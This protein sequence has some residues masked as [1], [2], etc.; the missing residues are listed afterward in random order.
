MGN[1]TGMCLESFFGHPSVLVIELRSSQKLIRSRDLNKAGLFLIAEP[2]LYFLFPVP[3]VSSSKLRRGSSRPALVAV[4][5]VKDDDLDSKPGWILWVVDR[6]PLPEPNRLVRFSP[7]SPD[8]LGR[9]LDTTTLFEV[10]PF[11]EVR[12]RSESAC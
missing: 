8:E 7:A 10:L 4:A 3:I 1:V 5:L 6:R 11:R 9:L 12:P 2:V